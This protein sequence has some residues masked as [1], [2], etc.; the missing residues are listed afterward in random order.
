VDEDALLEQH[1][2]DNVYNVLEAQALEQHLEAVVIHVADIAAVHVV[3][4]KVATIHAQ[5]ERTPGGRAL[6]VK[7]ELHKHAVHGVVHAKVLWL[8]RVRTRPAR[9]RGGAC[10]HRVDRWWAVGS[11]VGTRRKGTS[12]RRDEPAALA[13]GVS[14]NRLDNPLLGRM[15]ALPEDPTHDLFEEREERVVRDDAEHTRPPCMVTAL[16]RV[17]KVN[18]KSIGA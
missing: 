13:R 9:V 14:E 18:G 2:V 1:A 4:E 6:G 17:V 7:H 3:L 12:A 15:R 10:Q 8:L 11:Y 5:V 16:D